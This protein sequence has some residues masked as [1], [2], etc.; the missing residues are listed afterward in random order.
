MARFRIDAW[1]DCL[2]DCLKAIEMKSAN[3]KAYFYLAQAQL[4]L[5]HPNEALASA[6]TA[7][8]YGLRTGDQSTAKASELVL[9]AKKAVWEVKERD[10]LRERSHLLRELEDSLMRN[11]E[12]D[13][14]QVIDPVVID[15]IQN[16][17]RSKIEELYSIFAIAD[18]CNMVKREIPDYMVDQ[19]S[20][21]FMYD[22]VITKSGQSY[23]RTTIEAHLKISARDPLTRQS[24]S[25]SDL[26]SNLALKQACA[27]FLKE[28]GWAV[29]W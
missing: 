23:E 13:A 28:N 14:N 16:T 18:P 25:V 11:G 10:R 22:P 27:E 19:I 12:W 2:D 24:L 21:G 4:K 5:R 1:E 3:F 6:M 7:Y 29:E 9:S 17:T 8:D 26:V 20:F 15:E